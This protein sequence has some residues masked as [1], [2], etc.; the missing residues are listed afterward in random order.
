[1]SHSQSY[2]P[3]WVGSGRP[4]LFSPREMRGPSADRR[5]RIRRPVT[6]LALGHL[7]SAGGCPMTRAGGA[8]RRSTAASLQRLNRR[9]VTAPGRA[10][11]TDL[12]SCLGPLRPVGLLRASPA[13]ALRMAVPNNRSRGARSP[14]RQPAPGRGSIV[15]PDGAPTPPGCE[16]SA[17]PRRQPARPTVSLRRAPR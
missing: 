13:E 17:R 9:A 7:R 14:S 2:A 8:S 1:M 10:F 4:L 11:E 16:V 5:L 6:R 12:R 3:G 15:P